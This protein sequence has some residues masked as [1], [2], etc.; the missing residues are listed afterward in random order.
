MAEKTLLQ[1][2]ILASI[3]Q[4]PKGDTIRI[5]KLYIAIKDFLLSGRLPSAPS[6]VTDVC[7]ALQN[8]ADRGDLPN[9]S[10]WKND[11]RW[12]IRHARDARL[13]K[14]VG[15]PKSGVWVRI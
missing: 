6:Y 7:N 4:V 5:R 8:C 3:Q 12:A 14:H 13:I 11:V 10:R 1:T 15:T 2:F 9:E